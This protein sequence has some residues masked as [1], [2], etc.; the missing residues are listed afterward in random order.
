VPAPGFCGVF[1]CIANFPNGRGYVEQC[2]DNM[3]S[4]SGGIS[5]S[6]SHHGGNKQALY[7][8]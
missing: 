4:K 7:G 1:A 5:G 6:C 3:F 8:P 2:N